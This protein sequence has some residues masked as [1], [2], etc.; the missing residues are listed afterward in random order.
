[1]MDVYYRIKEGVGTHL[2][3]SQK[4]V[5]A[6]GPSVS[7]ERFLGIHVSVVFSINIS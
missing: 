4:P 2:Y 1:M 7:R 5:E 6:R 3:R